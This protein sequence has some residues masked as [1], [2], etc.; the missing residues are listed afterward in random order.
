MTMMTNKKKIIEMINKIYQQRRQNAEIARERKIAQLSSKSKDFAILSEKIT[1]A[2]LKLSQASL[3]QNQ[4]EIEKYSKILDSLLQKRTKL[5]IELGLGS[6]Y[7]EPEYTC[8]ACHD[9]GFIV[10]ENGIEVCRCRTQLFIEILYE[11]SKLKDILKEHNFK[12]FNLE[13]Y[14]KEIDPQ[15]GISPYENMLNIIKEVKKFVKNFDKSSQKGLLFYGSTG[16]GKTFLAHCI[17]KEIIDKKK[18][19]IFLDSIAFFEIL[20]EKYS[21]MVRLY[22]EVDD[23]EYK[24]LEE[25]DLLI[26]DDLGNE[27]KSPEF[28]HGVFQSLLDKRYMTNKKTVI[29]TNYNIDGLLK[30]YSD[31]TMGRLHEYFMFLH[32]FG[33]DIRVLKA[34]SQLERR[35]T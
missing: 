21:K 19:V 4:A 32:F 31:K 3:S 23:E 1:K 11:Q 7:L 35:A 9:T 13:Y 16:L 18:T 34:K 8:Q 28:C 6:N 29:T 27:G 15:E 12:N 24:S 14:S 20:K 33:D 30:L 25:V 2:G 17:A 26:I 5:L 22:D 10:S